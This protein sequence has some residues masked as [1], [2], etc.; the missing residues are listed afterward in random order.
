MVWKL[1]Q[2][3]GKRWRCPLPCPKGSCLYGVSSWE[4]AECGNFPLT[5][6]HTVPTLASLRRPAPLQ[7]SLG[8]SLHTTGEIG[9]H[10]FSTSWTLPLSM[11]QT[12]PNSAPYC[13]AVIRTVLW[14]IAPNRST[15][16]F[17]RVVPRHKLKSIQIPITQ[18]GLA[19]SMFALKRN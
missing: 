12:M 3:R 9:Q 19:R 6:H 11:A 1:K 13:R 8:I 2:R 17:C 4:N 5:Y 7:L 18:Q 10:G 14:A 16:S 15:Q